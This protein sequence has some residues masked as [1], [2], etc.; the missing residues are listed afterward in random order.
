MPGIVT[1]LG[2]G[3]V[4]NQ[5][6][7]YQAMKLGHVLEA[8]P[9]FVNH[10]ALA[11]SMANTQGNLAQNAQT[12]GGFHIASALQHQVGALL[13]DPSYRASV[14]ESLQNQTNP[15]Y[16]VL[17]KN[18]YY[19][20]TN[21]PHTPSPA[22]SNGVGPAIVTPI[23]TN[24]FWGPLGHLIHSAAHFVNQ[25]VLNPVEHGAHVYW[26]DFANGMSGAV[27]DL[28]FVS[29]AHFDPLHTFHSSTIGSDP[30]DRIS[31][32]ISEQ[33]DYYNHLYRYTVLMYRKY[34]WMGVARAL[35]PAVLGALATTALTLGTRGAA[36][37]EAAAIGADVT[38][39]LGG[40]AA[41]AAMGGEAGAA[42]GETAAATT[43]EAG[44]ET[45][46]T[47]AAES[48]ARTNMG[49]FGTAARAVGQT[50]GGVLRGTAA[51]SSRVSLGS[52]AGSEAFH[53][54]KL[55]E[56]SRN[57]MPGLSTIGRWAAQETGLQNT[58]LGSA[59]SGTID[60]ITALTEPFMMGGRLAPE[61]RGVLPF[62]ASK[63]VA[64]ST[65]DHWV[66]Q[67][68]S[69]AGAQATLKQI[70]EWGSAENSNLK[71]II[72]KIIRAYPALEPISIDLA[73]ESMRVGHN[74]ADDLSRRI[75]EILDRGQELHAIKFPSTGFYQMLKNAKVGDG[76]LAGF[77]SELFGQS[78]M[79]YDEESRKIVT[80]VIEFGDKNAEHAFGQAMQ[81]AGWK[82]SDINRIL[83]ELKLA[84]NP[85][86]WNN[87]YRNVLTE[88]A[89][90]NATKQFVKFVI[91]RDIS[92]LTHFDPSELQGISKKSLRADIKTDLDT[93]G[94][95]S[96][97]TISKLEMFS[98]DL[99]SLYSQLEKSIKQGIDDFVGSIH[100]G[101]EGTMGTSGRGESLANLGDQADV[102]AAPVDT[103]LAPYVFPNYV[104][105]GNIVRD[106]MDI[107]RRGSGIDASFSEAMAAKAV[108][109]GHWINTNLNEMWFKPLALLTPGWAMRVSI[110]ELGLNTFRIGPRNYYAGRVANAYLKRQGNVAKTVTKILNDKIKESDQ[111]LLDL[112]HR[113]KNPITE[114]PKV[115]QEALLEEQNY[116]AWLK[117]FDTRNE[118]IDL[119]EFKDVGRTQ[120][121][122]DRL[123]QSATPQQLELLYNQFPHL[124]EDELNVAEGMGANLNNMGYKV[125]RT[126]AQ[127]LAIYWRTIRA[128]FDKTM[129]DALGW[130]NVS[131]YV[132]ELLYKHQGGTWLPE[133]IG[134]K[135]SASLH[136]QDVA[137]DNMEVDS[138]K[139]DGTLKTKMLHN[140]ANP[141]FVLAKYGEK[142]FFDGWFAQAVH[143]SNS[144]IVG[145][146]A[147]QIYRDLYVGGLR[148]ESLHDAA[149]TKISQMLDTIHSDDLMKFQ[150]HYDAAYG[151]SMSPHQ[152]WA[153]VLSDMI[154]GVV[155]RQD[156]IM[157]PSGATSYFWQPVKEDLL[158]QMADGEL[159]ISLNAFISEHAMRDGKL[160]PKNE[161]PI[162]TVA[163][164][165]RQSFEGR[166]VSQIWHGVGDIVNKMSMLGHDKVL[167]NIVN[168]LVREPVYIY[169]YVMARKE[170]E[171]AVQ[172][173]RITAD[174]ASVMAETNASREMIRFIHNPKDK[175]KFEELMRIVSP[176]YF[177]K[178]QAWRRMGRLF[179]K[180]PGAFMQY[181]RSM[182][183]VVDWAQSATNKNGQSVWVL[184]GVSDWLPANLTGS[185]T[186]LA[187][188]DPLAS[189]QIANAFGGTTGTFLDYVFPAFGPAATIPLYGISEI[190]GI[191]ENPTAAK[192]F[193]QALGPIN[194]NESLSQ[195][196]YGVA[197]PNSMIRQ[198]IGAVDGHF[199]SSN[200]PADVLDTSYR[201][202][203]LEVQSEKLDQIIHEAAVKVEK[204]G[205]KPNDPKFAGL[206]A[207][208]VGTV[209]H[210][211]G[212]TNPTASPDATNFLNGVRFG[213]DLVMFAKF[214]LSLVSP[215]A[216]STGSKIT[217]ERNLLMKYVKQYQKQGYSAAVD[218]FITDHPEMAAALLTTSKSPNGY[219][220]ATKTTLNWVTVNNGIVNDYPRAALAYGPD[221]S[222][223][224]AYFQQAEN[225]LTAQGLSKK[226]TPEEFLQS[227]FTTVGNI[228][229]YNFVKPVYATAKK[230]N[231]PGAYQWEKDAI[232]TYGNKYNPYWLTNQYNAMPS[233][234]NKQQAYIQLVGGGNYRGLI[235][236]SRVAGTPEQMGRFASVLN[237]LIGS[238]GT[239]NSI[240][241]K[242]F[243]RA[244]RAAGVSG[245]LANN[246]LL[247]YYYKKI[248][249]DFVPALNNYLQAAA[250][251]Q[252]TYEDI[253]LWWDDTMNQIIKLV[254]A[255]QSGIETVFRG[256]G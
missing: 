28:N 27:R 139:K 82:S 5:Q 205:V 143:L 213:T 117:G 148:E 176:F 13:S 149:V 6:N 87:I 244:A 249:S 96:D 70:S 98:S 1:S 106:A 132:P 112:E 187:S 218:H 198:I 230:N 162:T 247:T 237:P 220:P 256:L 4:P 78:A 8:A 102:N 65:A 153:H 93:T 167:G 234:A 125:N 97:A 61:I 35:A 253:K 164:R 224:T 185:L 171:S 92:T 186:A 17:G 199:S 228:F 222:K 89:L 15:N 7:D 251:H 225:Y 239:M 81:Q 177:A 223:D 189:D 62:G 86:V 24:G 12:V 84:S 188:M 14:A 193:Q 118:A 67:Y 206:L 66:S 121:E 168:N 133:A 120:Q 30:Q 122:I 183:A 154:E 11:L 165:P 104:E 173:G 111:Y 151:H 83:G 184:P 37:G 141:E 235:N 175:T 123:L 200:A 245:D 157:L 174:Q 212:A 219:Y 109:A 2:M 41:S 49:P 63:S 47:T 26:S 252:Y 69:S 163:R 155:S 126:V 119:G 80:D 196:L 3:F 170:L 115:L 190:P 36:A 248:N 25:N 43:G 9:T 19:P 53:D 241:Q 68:R 130:D 99:G 10:P 214:G 55:W 34:G 56:T 48:A 58:W 238:K 105:L 134:A 94:R 172:A 156:K 90:R 233:V 250:K 229:A 146:K 39:A 180:N 137:I 211:G 216:I 107:V 242:D 42:A 129:L 22:Q 103:Q 91:D 44:A 95:L 18:D 31:T 114:D 243:Q 77:V 74:T 232:T 57:A 215:V 144:P 182:L 240:S 194:Y 127:N 124:A 40:E 108:K 60:S 33:F 145:R 135:H 76:K 217:P 201:N 85:E 236:D 128:G 38:G 166:G 204:M 221:M 197:M 64:L 226:Q 138:L 51:I 150:R 179:A 79:R 88:G 52:W 246:M 20:L 46:G 101:K 191:R 50:V 131:K 32:Q 73:R 159:P 136:E 207:E 75:S 100:A 110:S 54:Q 59:M 21:K 116:N 181:A 16:C 23:A 142:G 71:D 192:L 208:E 210:Q 140:V 178:N 29:G 255:L 158:N 202:A 160:L 72:G 152:S 231:V 169:E 254:P 203:E 195:F 113:I 147:V 209:F 227:F 45:T 161:L